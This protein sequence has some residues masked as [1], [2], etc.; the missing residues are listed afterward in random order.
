LT[1]FFFGIRYQKEEVKYK[2]LNKDYE[3]IYKGEAKFR[4]ANPKQ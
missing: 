2:K 4:E 1:E 3:L